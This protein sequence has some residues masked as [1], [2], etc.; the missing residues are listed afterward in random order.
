MSAPTTLLEAQQR[1]HDRE[2]T[3]TDLVQ[4]TLT[5]LKTW[6]PKIHAFLEIF[7]EEAQAAAQAV[8]ISSSATASQPLAGIPIAIKD[9]ICTRE[10]H[11]TAASKI[12]K[13][14]QAPYDGTV[15][16]RLREA[17]AIIIG[18]TNLDEF[19]MGSSTEYSAFG[20][21]K[22]PWDTSRVAGGSSG[23]SAAA[24]ASGE[25][26]AALGTDTGGSI[27]QPA[28]F[29]GVVG[30]KPTYGLVSRFGVLAYGSSLDQVGPI[31]RTVKDAALLLQILAGHD[32]FDATSSSQSAGNY[33]AACDRGVQ[34]LRI[35]IPKEFFGAGVD[36]EVS[37]VV[38]AAIR[39]LEKQGAV[40]KE[41][42]LP[43]TPAAIAV[44]Y[45]IAKSE[46]STNLARYDGL[47]FAPMQV[48][49]D[50]LLEYYGQIRGQGFGSEVKRAILMGTYALSAGYYDAWYKQASKVRTL[51][52]QEYQT[53]FKEVDVIAG[54]VAPEPAFSIGSKANDPLAMYVS[55]ALTVPLSVAGVPA[56]SVPCGFTSAG[57]PVGLQLAAA[58][59]QE[60]TL[61]QVARAYEQIN[62]LHEKHPVF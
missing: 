61:F 30:V 59:W 5:Q 43:L 16:T 41:I 45:I 39:R 58:H 23:G 6:E 55:D 29:C 31:T 7:E 44:Y 24:V 37:E 33:L 51:I 19:A 9:L 18:K 22:N 60:E 20:V 26:L 62:T 49:A 10:G 46:A 40:V 3:P 25:V 4:H 8:T 42:S 28:S 48:T 38:S 50:S 34:G 11:T 17:G 12:L 21:T 53:A 2:V 52:I 14:F 13:T 36:A 35:G 54:P 15:I 32:E 56:I 57:A 27:R 1:L 47:R